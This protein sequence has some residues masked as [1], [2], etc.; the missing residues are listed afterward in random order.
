[1][2]FLSWLLLAILLAGS[3]AH[4][5]TIRIVIPFAPGGALDPFARIMVNGLGQLRPADSIVVE[6]IGG[7]GGIARH[8]HRRQGRAGWTHAAFSPSGNIVINPAMQQQPAL[9][10][11]DR[12]RA[13]RADRFGQ[14]RADRARDLDAKSLA[15]LI[16]LAK[17]GANLTFGSPG[18]GTSP[19]ISGEM[20]NHSAGIP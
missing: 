6:N 14:D 15:E 12:I 4:A 8:E 11:G 17:C 13:G 9:R 2:R 1:M 7:A 3:A 5:D 16:A 20:L 10:L 18:P 19:H